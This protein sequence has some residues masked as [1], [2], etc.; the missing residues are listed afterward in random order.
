[1]ANNPLDAGKSNEQLLAERA[2]RVQDALELKRPDRIPL[3]MPAGYLLSEYGGVTHRVQQDDWET[4]QSLLEKFA[5]EFEPD[6]V[7]GLFN[8][9]HPS[10][11]LGDRMTKWPGY[12][13]PDTGSFQFDEHE[14]MKAE[15]YDAFLADPSDWTIRTYL[16]RAFAELEGL[17]YLPPFG[18]WAFGHYHLGNL[19]MYAAPPVQASLQALGKAIEIAAADAAK[20]GESVGR[21]AALGFPPTFLAGSLTEAPF[22]FMSD[23]LRGMRGIMLDILRR[24]EKLLAAEEKVLRFQ[25]EFAISFAQ[26]TGLK[27]AF[28]PLHR[29]SDGFMSLA[30]FEKFYWPQ[31]KEQMET[32]VAH[33]ITPVCFYEGVWDQRLKYLAE[34]PK[35]KTVG[36]FQSSDIFKVKEVVGDTM[37]I[38]GG[39]KNSL[40]QSGSVEQVREHTKLVCEVVGKDGGLIMSPGVGEMEGSDLKL[41]RAWADATREFGVY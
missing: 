31:L 7:L 40:L 4:A 29:G 12:G 2:K 38:I 22:D 10:L 3:H 11:A 18:M 1:M 17:R 25:L 24:P 41:I 5:L 20:L 19:P 28:I 32:L 26:A 15:D 13:L 36:W 14:F 34:L 33:D 39:M 8:N 37:C 35:G 6:V 16:P 30:Q 9:P 23:T 21:M 27:A